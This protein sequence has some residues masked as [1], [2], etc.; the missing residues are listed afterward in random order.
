VQYN[1]FICRYARMAMKH[2]LRKKY[3]NGWL[4]LK[5]G[6]LTEFLWLSMK[7]GNEINNLLSYKEFQ[8]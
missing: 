5:D 7:L 8:T 3:K 1:D 4:Y 2:A 6:N